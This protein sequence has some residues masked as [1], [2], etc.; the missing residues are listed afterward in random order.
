MT[1]E[2]LT[3]VGEEEMSGKVSLE[4]LATMTGFP[5]E[6]IKEEL[7]NGEADSQISLD[8]LR[9][10]MLKYIDSTMLTQDNQH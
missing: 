7:F 1:A 2:N 9:S 3:K 10:A 4:K 5:V 8:D 6:V